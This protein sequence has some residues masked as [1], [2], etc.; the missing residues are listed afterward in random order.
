VVEFFT[1][2]GV[3]LIVYYN[4]VVKCKSAHFGVSTSLQLRGTAGLPFNVLAK[5]SFITVPR[6]A[7]ESGE[8]AAGAVS[9]LS[10]MSTLYVASYCIFSVVYHVTALLST[11]S[12]QM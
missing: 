10:T 12:T 3:L 8:A 4:V 6:D 5:T 7:M 9:T 1:E 2:A 11:V